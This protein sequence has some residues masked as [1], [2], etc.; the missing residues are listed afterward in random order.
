MNYNKT[1]KVKMKLTIDITDIKK[2][3][4][5]K[6][7]NNAIKKLHITKINFFIK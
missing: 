4:K 1:A 5:N 6:K 2:R 3:V 7:I